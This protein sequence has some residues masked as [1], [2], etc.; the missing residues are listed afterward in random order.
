MESREP[1]FEL[2]NRRS[3]L[4]F[5][6]MGSSGLVCE[7]HLTTERDDFDLHHLV[8]DELEIQVSIWRIGWWPYS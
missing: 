4:R 6:S 2:P 8:G 3:N 5:H 1:R 7:A